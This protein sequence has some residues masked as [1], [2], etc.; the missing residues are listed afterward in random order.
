V[1]LRLAPIVQVEA[2]YRWRTTS[3]S[4]ATDGSR[5]SLAIHRVTSTSAEVWAGTLFP[6]MAMPEKARLRITDAAGRVRTTAIARD[7]WQRPFTKLTQ[8]FFVVR[9]FSQLSPGATYRAA[10]D[11]QVVQNGK[12]VWQELR[13][14]AF[15]TLPASIPAEGQRPFTVGLGS[16]FYDHRDGGNAAEA[17]KLLFE[18]PDEAARPQIKFLTGDQVYLDIGFD[19]L[20]PVPSELRERIANDYARQ[21]QGLGSILARGGSWMLPD[22][23]EY[24]NDYPYFDSLIPTLAALQLSSVRNAWKQ[25]A[26]DGVKNVQRSGVVEVFDIGKDI[27]FCVADLRSYRGKHRGQKVMLHPDSFPDLIR[28]ARAL[29]S[30][31]VLV[32]SQPLIVGRDSERNLLSFSGQYRE[33]LDALGHTGHDVV[34]LTG[35]VHYG[36]IGT[37]LLGP[38]GGRLIEI[39]A[40]PLSNLTLINSISTSD[41][42]FSP[43][44]FPDASIAIPG[45]TPRHVS[46]ARAHSVPSAP[47]GFGSPYVKARTKE[48]FVT[49]SFSRRQDGRITLSAQSWLVREREAGG[50]LPARG[51]PSPFTTVLA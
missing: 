27:S 7:Q 50:T 42:M 51:F 29:K 5:W 24:W 40:S 45:W 19:S 32:L 25:A 13:T 10:F 36:R 43:E 8:R 23:H 2:H 41:A 46:Y 15:E 47:G 33:L 44:S 34:L 1:R 26:T 12:A 39:I 14:G 6:S 30:P 9:R 49:V 28:W 22:D 3:M 38:K 31:G 16:C 11:R 21:W 35:D 4:E 20:S 18:H 48:H 17:Y 37:C